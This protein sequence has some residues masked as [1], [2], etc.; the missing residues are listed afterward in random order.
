[1]A[2][3]HYLS[4]SKSARY[5]LSGPLDST[6]RGVCFVLHGY[7]QLAEFFIRPFTD[8]ALRDVLFIAPEGLHRFYLD[9]S[10]GRVGASWMTKEDR[11]KDIDDYCDYLDQ[12]REYIVPQVSLIHPTEIGVLGFSQGA[13]TAC[14]WL[15]HSEHSFSYLVNYAGLY[16]PDLPESQ[17]LNK[18][19][20]T[21]VVHALGDRDEYISVERMTES[22]REFK[23]SG[24]PGE[25]KVFSGTHKIYPAVV[26]QIFKDL[27]LN[28]YP[29][30]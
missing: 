30:S 26:E 8:K 29:L 14:R 15:S 12:L 23:Q 19:Q 4:V 25:L 10:K 9:G 20:K 16:P 27:N 5:Y 7:G 1:M 28:V 22:L 24:F 18:M 6:Y 13:A 11:L 2:D 3:V 21:R 17:A